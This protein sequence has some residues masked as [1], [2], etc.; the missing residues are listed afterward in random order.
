MSPIMPTST[1]KDEGETTE[2]PV[3]VVSCCGGG[4]VPYQYCKKDMGYFMKNMRS[5][6]D[7]PVLGCPVHPH[8]SP[9]DLLLERVYHLYPTCGTHDTYEAYDTRERSSA[10]NLCLLI[11]EKSA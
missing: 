1:P 3:V 11:S 9:A 5:E 8:P 6:S 2:E 4:K 10:V 7:P